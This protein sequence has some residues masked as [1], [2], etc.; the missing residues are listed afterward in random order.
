M[1]TAVLFAI[2]ALSLSA[3]RKPG[4]QLDNLPSNIE[5]LTHFGERADISPDNRRIAFMVKS[6]GDAMTIDLQTRAI[7]CLTCNVPAAAFLRVMHL[8]TGDYVLIGPEHFQDIRTSRARDN[9]LWFLSKEPGSKPVRLDQ[10]MSEGAAISKKSLKIAFSQTHEQ[11]PDLPDGASRL[12]V[13]DVELSSGS[14]KLVNKKTVHESK[15]RNCVIEAQDFYDNDTKM[16]FTCYEPQ[17]LASVMDI[18]LKSG[19]IVNL[20]KAPG[21]YNE[22]EGIF[23]DGQYTCVESDR[24]V[25]ELG[26]RRGSS[27]IDIWKLKLDGTGKDFVRLTHF[28]DYEGGKASN[29][30]VSTDG[31]FMAFQT[32]RTTDPAGVGYGIVLY[33]FRK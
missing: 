21:A 32:A 19:Q 4:S 16:T 25:T 8:V 7:R 29:P 31:R 26:G 18:D 10:K 6:F 11:A 20:S 1:K 9:E 12:I 30:V 15:D 28:N 14:A 22:V 23:P 27:N 13:A 33:W 5:V 2:A 24:Q 3:Q 17:G